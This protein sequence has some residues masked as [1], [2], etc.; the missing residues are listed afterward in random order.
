MIHDAEPSRI[1][2]GNVQQLAI[3]GYGELLRIGAAVDLAK[4]LVLRDVEYADAVRAPVRQRQGALINPGRGK[5]LT[6][7]R[8]EDQLPI[9]AWMDAPAALA[10]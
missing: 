3:F 2:I 4:H 5:R 9:H 7:Q 8:H 6:A 1:L 10:Q